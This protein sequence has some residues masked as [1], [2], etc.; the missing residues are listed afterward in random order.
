LVKF[1]AKTADEFL[2]DEGR[3][4]EFVPQNI[5]PPIEKSE[6]PALSFDNLEKNQLIENLPTP[7][8]GV[9]ADEPILLWVLVTVF[10]LSIIGLILLGLRFWKEQKALSAE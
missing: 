7:E 5:D 9:F 4:F 2:L 10:A 1:P 8:S 3:N 6:E